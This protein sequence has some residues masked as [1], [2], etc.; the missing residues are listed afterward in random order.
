MDTAGDPSDYTESKY[1]AYLKSKN[2]YESWMELLARR[3]VDVDSKTRI[4][5]ITSSGIINQWEAD[6]GHR[7]LSAELEQEKTD[8]NNKIRLIVFNQR[9]SR[10]VQNELGPMYDI[11]P[12][13]FRAVEEDLKD[14][15]DNIRGY[16]SVP[17][18]LVGGQ[19][20][21]LALGYGWTCTIKCNA[22]FKVGKLS[23]ILNAVLLI[24]VLTRNSSTRIY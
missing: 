7:I 8:L 4:V 9:D 2:M 15:R 11:D 1:L 3:T 17:E 16:H 5:D 19:P 21:H 12:G 6:N 24:V 10:N 18:F 13:F 23:G 14:Y 20:Q 22:N